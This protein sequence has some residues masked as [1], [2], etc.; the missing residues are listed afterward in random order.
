MKS[1]K[2]LSGDVGLAQIEMLEPQKWRITLPTRSDGVLRQFWLHIKYPV[3]RKS[4]LKGRVW[5]RAEVFA[6][7]HCPLSKI[8][9]FARIH[10]ESFYAN[11][12]LRG[13][14]DEMP[15]IYFLGEPHQIQLLP[16]AK[17]QNIEF[18]PEKLCVIAGFQNLESAKPCLKKKM[19][20]LGTVY[21]APIWQNLAKQISPAPP[22]TWRWLRGRQKLGT[23]SRTGEIS[24]NWRLVQM[25]PEA[26][27]SVIAH[28]F[29][30]L[31]EFNHSAAFYAEL[32]RILPSWQEGEA[33]LQ[34]HSHRCAWDF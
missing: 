22:P 2:C 10:A 15:P 7:P 26:V 11:L 17:Q 18:S 21:I 5:T 3:R 12:K 30:H 6:P 20:A 19:Q 28:E 31:K 16:Q 27:A 25:P 13:L 8:Q 23:C 29:A 9:N 1:N 14:L 32:T 4:G 34:A 24:L 33:W